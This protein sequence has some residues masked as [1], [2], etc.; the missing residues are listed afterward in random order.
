[1]Q[2]LKRVAVEERLELGI[3]EG[4]EKDVCALV[5]DEILSAGCGLSAI[6]AWWGR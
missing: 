5:I 6:D 3:V 2:E 1:M 4:M